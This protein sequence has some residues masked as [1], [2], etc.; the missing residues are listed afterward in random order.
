MSVTDEFLTYAID[1]LA[2]LGPVTSRRMFGGAGLYCDGLMFAIVVDDTLYF[3]VG[4]SNRADYEAEGMEP[5]TYTTDRGTST[6][7][8]YEV[9]IDILESKDTCARW[10]HKALAV[11]HAA[12][13]AKTK[14]TKK[15]RKS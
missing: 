10:A 8:Y 14:K 3:K 9:P 6:M 12:Q 13:K 15:K 5:F 2:E 7:S 1:Q 4:N 11:A